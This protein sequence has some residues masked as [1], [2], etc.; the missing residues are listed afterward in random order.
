MTV[1]GSLHCGAVIQAEFL[2]WIRQTRPQL[3]VTITTR[4]PGLK[5]A[6]VVVLEL[7]PGAGVKT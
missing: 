6:P 5:K 2:V 1:I 4:L 7:A 3:R